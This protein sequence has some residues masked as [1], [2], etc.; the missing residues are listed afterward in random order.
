MLLSSTINLSIL[1]LNE[2]DVKVMEELSISFNLDRAAC[3]LKLC[4]YEEA[5]NHCNVL[6][7]D[8]CNI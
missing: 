6:K 7:L 1:P 2:E 5:K 4:V 8:F 3:Q